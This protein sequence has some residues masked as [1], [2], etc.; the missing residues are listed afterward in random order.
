MNL[1]FIN[2]KEMVVYCFQCEITDRRTKETQED[3]VFWLEPEM[4]E[5]C[6]AHARDRIIFHCNDLGYDVK[7]LSDSAGC[8]KVTVNKGSL[9]ICGEHIED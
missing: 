8:R 4:T 5:D 2:D 1:D 3:C 7:F 9:F 6:E